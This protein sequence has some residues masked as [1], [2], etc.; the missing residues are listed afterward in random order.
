MRI[1]LHADY[2]TD[3]HLDQMVG[4]GKPDTGARCGLGAGLARAAARNSLRD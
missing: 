4:R 3:D 1:D 2:S